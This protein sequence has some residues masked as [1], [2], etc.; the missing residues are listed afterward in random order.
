MMERLLRLMAERK[1]S[2]LFLSPGSP[3]MLKVNGAVTQASEQRLDPERVRALVREVVSDEDWAVFE[4][5][6]ELTVG[7]GVSGVGTF[8][9][10]VFRQR[11]S[12][13]SVVR[14]VPGDIPKPAALGLPEFLCELIVQRRGLMLVVGATGSGKSTTLASLLDYRNEER[15]GHILTLEDPIEYTFRNRRSIVNQRQVGTDTDSFESALRS[16]M[17]Q[18]PDCILIGEIRD[19]ETMAKAIAYAQSGH[20]VVSTMHAN[21]AYHALTRIV[22][23]FPPDSRRIVLADLA[24]TLKAIVSQRLVRATAG[25]RIPA[26]EVLLNTTHIADLIEHGRIGEIK[27]AMERSLA[28]GSVTFEQALVRMVA[29]K[30]ISREEAL[31]HADSATNLL[32]LLDNIDSVLLDEDAVPAG[33]ASPFVTQGPGSSDVE[34]LATIP[35]KGAGHD[36]FAFT[37]QPSNPGERPEPKPPS[38]SEFLLNI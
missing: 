6:R 7:H 25:E 11:G 17:R 35:P 12:I 36:A 34:T 9:I 38:F 22:S 2:D 1:A 30:R 32:W 28:T 37:P 10:N 5:E 27:E 24:A 15:A 3:V 16:A 21:N 14:Y 8:R 13:S 26:V 33:T 29:N 4:R 23:F 31:L 20:M 18:A 19:P